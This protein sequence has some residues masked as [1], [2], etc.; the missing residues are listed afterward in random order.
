MCHKNQQNKGQHTL[1]L[2]K[3]RHSGVYRSV[4]S[5]SY[6]QSVRLVVF[7]WWHNRSIETVGYNL[8][9]ILFD[10]IIY[11]SLQ[12]YWKFNKN[13]WLFTTFYSINFI[14]SSTSFTLLVVNNITY[15]ILKIY[16]MFY[17]LC[18]VIL[19]HEYFPREVVLAP[20]VLGELMVLLWKDQ[21]W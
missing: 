2:F 11:T 5:G 6:F 9:C 13:Q 8:I 15:N 7:I 12:K 16:V 10:S 3:I 17:I 4:L 21:H 20:A 19:V 1:R 14:M 18:S